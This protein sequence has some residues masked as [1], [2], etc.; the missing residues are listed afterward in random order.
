M[1]ARLYLEGVRMGLSIHPPDLPQLPHVHI[2]NYEIRSLH[3]SV[4]MADV[5]HIMCRLVRISG[6]KE[7]LCAYAD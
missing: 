4:E 3:G 2:R 7:G 5:R 1:M 6:Y